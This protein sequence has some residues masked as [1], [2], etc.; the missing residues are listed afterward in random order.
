MLSSIPPC[1]C[2]E[3]E[4]ATARNSVNIKH[5]T[6]DLVIDITRPL[7]IHGIVAATAIISVLEYNSTW[8]NNPQLTIFI[9]L[10]IEYQQSRESGNVLHRFYLKEW[11]ITHKWRVISSKL[12]LNLESGRNWILRRLLE[13]MPQMQFERRVLA[14]GEPWKKLCSVQELR[15]HLGVLRSLVI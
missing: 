12:G 11:Y 2:T 4:D 14:C 3:I 5:R 1:A 7:M 15:C 10:I 13:D 8:K 6:N 9:P